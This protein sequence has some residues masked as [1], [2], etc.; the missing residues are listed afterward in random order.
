MFLLCPKGCERSVARFQNGTVAFHGEAAH[1]FAD[2]KSAVRVAAPRGME[3]EY[4]AMTQ[5]TRLHATPPALEFYD[6]LHDVG[7]MFVGLEWLIMLGVRDM[8]RIAGNVLRQWSPQVAALYRAR[9]GMQPT[10]QALDT[11]AVQTATVRCM[12][13][14]LGHALIFSGASNPYAPDGEAGAD[15]YAGKFDAAGGRSPDLGAIFFWSIGCTGASCDHPS[16][17]IRASAHR[18]GF[19]AQLAENQASPFPR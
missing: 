2:Q 17:D 12:A 11:F 10:P 18:A 16:P 15:Y 6:D 7:G 13:H 19:D 4:A 14:E 1:G 3:V 9:T 5:R 8:Q